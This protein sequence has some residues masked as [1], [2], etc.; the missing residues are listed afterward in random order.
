M[1]KLLI[2]NEYAKVRDPNYV[3]PLKGDAKYQVWKRKLMNKM[4]F[5]TTAT[6]GADA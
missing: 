2:E 3:K 1:C 6:G 4:G 5:S